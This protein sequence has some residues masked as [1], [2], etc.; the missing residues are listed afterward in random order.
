LPQPFTG[1]PPAG[2]GRLHEIKH[3][4]MRIMRVFT[5]HANDFAVARGEWPSNRIRQI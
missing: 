3:E 4:S 5:R 2:D 1:D